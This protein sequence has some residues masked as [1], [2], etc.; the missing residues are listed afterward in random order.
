[1]RSLIALTLTGAMLVDYSGAGQRGGAPQRA[2]RRG[3][4]LI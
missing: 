2:W 1:L 4:V 3:S